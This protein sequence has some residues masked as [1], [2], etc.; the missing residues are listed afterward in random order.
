MLYI[1][2][3]LS[4]GVYQN[5]MT[6]FVFL[7]DLLKLCCIV[8]TLDRFL[9]II[10]PFRVCLLDRNRTRRLMTLVWLLAALLSALPLAYKPYFQWDNLHIYFTLLY[11]K[12]L[13]KKYLNISYCH[14]QLIFEECEGVCPKKE[15][16][17]MIKEQSS[18]RF[19]HISGHR[20][21]DSHSFGS[22]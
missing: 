2:K 18:H 21:V 17:P 13:L 16:P 14:S 15:G 22:K 19:P 7:I 1:D 10:F 11:E 8:I 20:T 3:D 5:I 12:C 6:S 9:V 4:I